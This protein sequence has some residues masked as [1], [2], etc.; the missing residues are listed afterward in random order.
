MR[1]WSL[2]RIDVLGWVLAC[3]AAAAWGAPPRQVEIVYETSR[4]GI[5]L[6][7]V[8]DALEH[9]GGNYQLTET[10]EGARA[11]YALRRHARRTS[12]GMVTPEGLQPGEFTDE[13]TGRDTARA[14]VRL[15]GTDRHA[16][17]QGRQA[18]RA[19]AAERAGSPL[20]PARPCLCA[21]AARSRVRTCSTGA[22]SRIT[23]IRIGGQ[24][25][26]Q[27]SDRRVR[28]IAGS[29]AAAA[30]SAS[31][32]WLATELGYL[33][34]RVLVIGE[35]RHALRA[36]G[37]QD[38][39]AVRPAPG[40]LAHAAAA[41]S[42]LLRILATCRRDLVALLPRPPRAWPAGARL[43]RGGGVR[44]A[45]QA[46]VRSKRRRAR[47]RRGARR[48][49][50]ASRCSACRRARS[51][52]WSSRASQRES[53]RSRSHGTAGRG[54]RR[55]AGLALGHA[56]GR[57]RRGASRCASRTAMLNP[58]PLDSARQSRAHE[59]R[60]RAR[61][62]GSRRHRRRS[63][64]RIRPAG[65]RVAGKPAINR[66]ALFRDG[67]I[68][69]QDEGSQLL[70]WLL[71]AAPRRD[72]RRLLR[73]RRRQDARARHADARHRTRLRDGRFGQAAGCAR[74]AR[75]RAPES[76]TSTRSR[77]RAITTRAQSGSPASSTACWS[78]RR[79]AASARCGAIPTSN[80]ATRTEAV[81]ELAQS[82]ARI[83]RAAARL[84]K[85]GGRLVY[86]TCS[87][88]QAENEAIADEF[89]A[90]HPEFESLSCDAV[91]AEQRIP[92]EAGARLRLWPHV[93]GTDGFFAAAFERRAP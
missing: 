81:T 70:A 75:R 76:P 30:T 51:R 61:A 59:P 42:R 38:H 1:N 57:L 11:F 72:G 40:M 47:P 79:A 49:R 7:E 77:F 4:N 92:L 66:H 74:A 65:L 25:S 9:D 63:P 10:T 87:I 50:A 64:P 34:V 82:S 16:A 28:R 2:L 20:V 83:L 67:L 68:E 45:A 43:R 56:G 39:H 17:I 44:G 29:C 93:H 69:V 33:P 21:A 85:P 19:A 35:G 48:R 36:G 55:P 90:A 12:R 80:G 60:R 86:A 8:T 84:V 54:A 88:L 15:E 71:G 91:L 37:D 62:P 58:A 24:R 14:C 78:M 52:G 46:R 31:E 18:H 73:R 6:A 5:T 53:A 22:D 32:V 23:S 89:A 27:D 41:L 26:G 13:R 3:F